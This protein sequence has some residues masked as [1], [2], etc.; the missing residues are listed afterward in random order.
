MD[1]CKSVLCGVERL[2][3]VEEGVGDADDGVGVAEGGVGGELAA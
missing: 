2:A 1:G 3:V